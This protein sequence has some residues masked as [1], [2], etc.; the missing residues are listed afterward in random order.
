M[1]PTHILTAALIP[2]ACLSAPA[3]AQDKTD[4]TPDKMEQ[5]DIKADDI[6]TADDGTVTA[7]GD[8][9]ILETPEQVTTATKGKMIVSDGKTVIT[10]DDITTK[11]KM[12]KDKMV[13]KMD[14]TAAA[15]V[16]ADIACPEG[17]TAQDNG[18]CMITGDYAE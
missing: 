14:E 2:W 18:T 9:L 8:P 16:I 1:R 15:P 5:M 17:T 11:S 6:M 3:F 10:A 7:T 13:T 4:K 12:T